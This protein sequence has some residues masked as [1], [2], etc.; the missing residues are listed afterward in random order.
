MYV[1]LTLDT[2]RNAIMMVFSLSLS[3]TFYFFNPHLH[4][5]HTFAFIQ[6]TIAS[7]H[8]IPIHFPI[9]GYTIQT[10]PVAN[11]TFMHILYPSS[12]SN[13][14]F[15]FAPMI[16]H[17]PME[18]FFFLVYFPT[19]TCSIFLPLLLLLNFSLSHQTNVHS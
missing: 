11:I 13:V 19:F 15:S 12:P 2:M 7:I 17:G 18:C 10:N 9:I 14:Y 1:L 5:T 4:I 6:V 8:C 3:F 16:P